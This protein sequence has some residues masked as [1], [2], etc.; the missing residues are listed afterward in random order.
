MCRWYDIVGFIE[1]Y[2]AH[3]AK[4]L[5][6][7]TYVGQKK[8]LVDGYMYVNHEWDIFIYVKGRHMNL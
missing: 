2:K 5:V 3:Y 4:K 8:A 7:S 6:Y 1:G